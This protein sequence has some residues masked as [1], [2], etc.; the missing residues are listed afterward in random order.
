MFDNLG[1]PNINE[2]YQDVYTVQ[3]KLVSD[4]LLGYFLALEEIDNG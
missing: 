3:E 4:V 1:I 2:V